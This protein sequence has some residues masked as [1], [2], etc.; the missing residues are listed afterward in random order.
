MT[1]SATELADAPDRRAAV[2]T[3]DRSVVVTAGAGTGKTT[4]LIERLVHLLLRSPEPLRITEIVAL[5]FTN[6]AADE[7]KLR[8]RQRLQDFLQS[9]VEREPASAPER[10]PTE[11]DEV[12]ALY[13][14][15]KDQLESRVHDA[16]RN[17]ER[18]DLGTIHTFAANLLRLYPLEAG[19]DP[20]FQ[21]D[22][23]SAFERL[24]DEQW[25]LW[26]DQELSLESA[27]AAEWQT[28]LSRCRLDQVKA[29]A[30]SL[31]M[32][33]VDLRQNVES[34]T[35]VPAALR[36]WLSQLENRA[37]IL[38]ERHPEDRVNEKLLRAAHATIGEFNQLGH[39]LARNAEISLLFSEKSLSPTTKGWS[40]EDIKEAQ[41][42]VR[43]AKGLVCVDSE[44]IGLLWR[45]LITYAADFRERF[46]R[47]GHISFDGLLVRARDLVRD[48]T[49]VRADLKRRYRAI[50]LDEF[51]DT[52]PIQYE[53][54]LYLA[55]QSAHSA[56]D[57][58]RVK[59]AP[60][61]I[62]VVG[63]PKQSIYAFRR[64]DIEAYLEIVEKVI[65]AQDGIECRLT[66]N[67]RSNGTILDVI[68]GVFENLIQAQHG[69]QPPYIP[70]FP[71]PDRVSASSSIPK[72]LVRKIIS[73][74][75]IDA[76]TARHLEGESLAR[77]LKGE[78]IGKATIL[79]GRGE[80]ARA[81]SKDVA[82][83]LRKLTDIHDYLLPLRREG[84]RYIVEGERHFYATKEIIDAVNLLRAVEN[85]YD[86]LALVGVLR[87]PL[88]GL[89]D[90]Q[91][92]ELH[93]QNLLNYHAAEKLPGKKFPPS[94]A[95]LYNA[96]ARLHDQTRALPIG[97]AIAQVFS[98]LPVEL[99]AAC[100]F[101]GEQA[102]AN[103]QKL[104]KEAERLGREGTT[105]L[106]EAIR[107]LE[108]R[109][110]EVKDEG[111]SALAEEHLDAVRIM[112]IHKAKGLEFPIVILAG[113]HTG[114]EGGRAADAEAL[115]DWSTGLIG[116]R[117]GQ[118]SDLA[119]LY[120]AEKSR[121][122]TAEE[123][124]RLLYVGMTRAREHL[125]ISC[126]AGSRRS[127][128]SFLSMLD[129]TLE[130]RIGAAQKAETITVGKGT[131]AIEVVSADLTAPSAS[132]KSA[133]KTADVN[134]QD[135]IERWRRRRVNYGSTGRK[136]P[137]VT[138]SRLKYQEQA[139]TEAGNPK[140]GEVYGRP[141]ALVMGDLAHRFLQQWDFADDVTRF[142]GVLHDWLS[143]ALSKESES[144]PA[145]T[146]SELQRIF[147]GFIRSS[148]YSE[149]ASA[150][151][152]GREVPLVMPWHGQIMEGIIDLIYEKNG[153][154]YLADYKTDKIARAEISHAV[155]RYRQQAEIYLT[156]VEQSLGR[157]PA[158][159]KLIFLRLGKAVELGPQK[160]KQ[161]LWLF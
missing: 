58:R 69:L 1:Q 18:S 72:L 42:V 49:R 104:A 44:L 84:I 113:C 131:I 93:R 3:F 77:W 136:A 109:V 48:H 22:D 156:A 146:E 115:F 130:Q 4:L 82:I 90:Q 21:E 37:A 135:F 107:Q 20:Q 6:K 141:P 32:E 150:R 45:L 92:Y 108:K 125:I 17:L 154:L 138:P 140:D 75:D 132:Q 2:T 98:T 95:D 51:Q 87:S 24:F 9:A 123:Q 139:L 124:K 137:F 85:P 74:H 36:E 31:A 121:F 102:V 10:K 54:L 134:W 41:M 11:I 65:Q 145:E 97:A 133:S 63:D 144:C 66:T 143:D 38:L 101:H 16:L 105:T 64:A 94:L 52:D 155:E 117:I 81:Q 151:I 160:L 30:K 56:T 91:I 152:L 119:G 8:L 128:G 96:L 127:R 153:L 57:W 76:E 86:R 27:R 71:A 73:A 34:L 19:L 99:L 158:A 147:A 116:V 33:N 157:S 111:E 26:L 12:I 62:F 25:S 5:T 148:A 47:E 110:L 103:L 100:Y 80:E 142:E 120:I 50:L 40:A 23:G 35:A 122:R 129:S 114:V 15:S 159:F 118:I 59:V 89:T 83:L 67:F 70:L 28:I 29:L 61:K 13:G 43:A 39:K 88:G 46:V 14:L 55:E 68:N 60:G 112:S 78:V 126:A 79:N 106:K 53:I 149:I 161:E 7:L